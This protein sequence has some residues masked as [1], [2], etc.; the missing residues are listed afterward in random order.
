MGR[1]SPPSD[2]SALRAERCRERL[3]ALSC[4]GF[5]IRSFM[6]RAPTAGLFAASSGRARQSRGL[7]GC[8][9]GTAPGGSVPDAPFEAATNPAAPPRYGFQTISRLARDQRRSHDNTIVPG[10][11]QLALNPIAAR[12]GLIAEP[13]PRPE[14]GT[15]S[16]QSLHNR[17]RVRDLA[18]LAHTAPAARRP[19]RPRS[20]PYARQGQMYVVDLSKTRLLCMR[21][22]AERP[23]QPSM[24]LHNVRRVAP[25]QANMGSR[26]VL[27]HPDPSLL[28]SL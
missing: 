4:P 28:A 25:S 15:A 26:G 23:A 27:R 9:R 17:R 14:A 6:K 8:S 10:E 13:Q 18:I 5:E 24:S 22:G 2:Q 11:A 21:L 20:Y 19:A 12:S 1:H 7:E 3:W 16:S